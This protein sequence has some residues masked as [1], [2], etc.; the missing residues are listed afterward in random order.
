MTTCDFDKMYE[1]LTYYIVIL[2]N[3]DI[4]IDKKCYFVGLY[5]SF[6]KELIDK[7]LY[8]VKNDN[9]EDINISINNFVKDKRKNYIVLKIFN[10]TDLIII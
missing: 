10:K 8:I 4:E 2:S 1:R 3:F 5:N 9:I 7:E 6:T